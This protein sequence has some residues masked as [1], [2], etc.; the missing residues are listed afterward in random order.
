MSLVKILEAIAINFLGTQSLE[1][2]PVT[3]KA[4]FSCL[5]WSSRNTSA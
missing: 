2:V 5:A 3:G 1:I 4:Q